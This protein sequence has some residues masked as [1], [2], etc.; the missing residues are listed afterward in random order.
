MSVLSK[1]CHIYIPEGHHVV[2]WGCL[3]RRKSLQTEQ[4]HRSQPSSCPCSHVYVSI[5]SLCPCMQRCLKLKAATVPAV[6]T[7]PTAACVWTR[8]GTINTSSEAAAVCSLRLHQPNFAIFRQ[9]GGNGHLQ[10]NSL[11]SGHTSDMRLEVVPGSASSAR[12]LQE[13]SSIEAVASCRVVSDHGRRR[14]QAHV[15]TASVFRKSSSYLGP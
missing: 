3:M 13:R 14:W 15:P 12:I 11:L 5:L 10:L 8:T 1:N 9:S 7:P 6:N 4:H 2:I